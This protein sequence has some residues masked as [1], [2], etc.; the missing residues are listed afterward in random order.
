MGRVERCDGDYIRLT[1]ETYREPG[2]SGETGVRAMGLVILKS[3]IL[4]LRR[5]MTKGNE[6]IPPD[7]FLGR[8]R[9]VDSGKTGEIKC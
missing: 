9:E 7:S 6:A 3:T 1:F 2:P 8:R 4:E 5:L